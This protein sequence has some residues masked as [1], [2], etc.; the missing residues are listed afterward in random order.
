MRS[1]PSIMCGSYYGN[2]GLFPWPR[3]RK[4]QNGVSWSVFSLNLAWTH[5]VPTGLFPRSFPWPREKTG[6]CNVVFSLA[7]FSQNS[8]EHSKCL[9]SVF[10]LRCGLFPTSKIDYAGIPV[11]S[12]REKTKGKDRKV[13]WCVHPRNMIGLFPKSSMDT[14]C[15][16][17]SF[18]WP[19]EKTE[20]KDRGT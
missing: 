4:V 14:L 12:L 8:Y 20:G 11:F 6:S 18:P 13:Q 2:S 9:K 17:R 7:V 1:F 16:Y 15:T 10:S 19:R 5:Y 3:D